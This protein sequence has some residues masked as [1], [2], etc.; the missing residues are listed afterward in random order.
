MS[1]NSRAE[2][3]LVIGLDCADPV[4]M[5]EKYIDRL[6]NIKALSK[7]GMFGPMQSC[8]P[9]ITVPAW[10][11]MASSKDPGQLGVYGFRN[12]SD[13]SYDKLSFSTSLDIKEPRLWDL[14]TKVGKKSFTIGVPGTF[15]PRPINGWSIGC[16]L[17]PSVDSKYTWPLDLKDEVAKEFGE[18]IIDVKGYRTDKKDWLLDQVFK[19][20][21]Q[22]FAMA[23]HF[24]KKYDWDLF[25][26]VDMG[27]DRLHHGF[28]Q[29][30]DPSHRHYV[31]G[32][33]YED[34]IAKYYEFVDGQIGE[35]LKLVDLDTT[36]VWVVSDHGAKC[37]TGGVCFNDWLIQ[38][39]YLTLTTKPNKIT[40]FSEVTIDWSKTLAWG[41]GGYYGRCFFNVQGR[42]SNGQLSK[43]D[44]EAFAK[45]LTQELESMVDH[46]GK[47]MGTK[48]YRPSDLYKSVNAVPPDLIVLFG[49]LGWRSVGSVGNPSV[50]TFENDTGP[51]DA[52]HNT[53][54]LFI[55]S[56]PSN[57]GRTGRQEITLYD[58]APTVLT[59]MGLPVPPDM[60]GKSF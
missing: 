6:P 41:E 49:N 45:K 55:C 60:I 33:P 3:V 19:M 5:F 13:W 43:S 12:R 34:A 37:M 18:Y 58:F 16:F 32:G 48:A 51:D 56:R 31:K 2:K 28:W 17:T 40:K 20:G 21:E 22:R 38:K 10:S 36:A 11:C 50:Y 7:R 8:M 27:V 59:Q 54:G 30:M 35:L 14:M 9:P 44:Y 46:E 57:T 52:N 47:P 25:W 15:P 26:F 4:L 53:H 39:G 42:E 24:M 23:R 1:N 29:F